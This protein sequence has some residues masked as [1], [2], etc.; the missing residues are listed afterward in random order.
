ME[1]EELYAEDRLAVETRIRNLLWTVSGNYDLSCELDIDSFQKA[2]EISL[3]DAIKQGAFARFFDSEAFG[4][5]LVKKIY[6]G[7]DEGPLMGISQLCLDEASFGKIAA[8]RP[9][10]PDIRKKAFEEILERDFRKLNESFAGRLK[11]AYMRRAL[12]GDCAGEQKIRRELDRVEALRETKETMEIIRCVDEIYNSAVD[13]GFERKHGS[14]KDVLAVSMADLKKYDWKDYLNEEAEEARMEEYLRQMQN[15]LTSLSEEDEKEKEKSKGG[16]VLLDEE[17]VEKMYSYME[18]NYGRS[19]LNELEQQRINYRLCRGAHADC[20]LYFTDGIL[21]ANVKI[22]AQSELARRTAEMNRRFHHQNRRVTRQNIEVLTEI[23]HHA[24]MTRNEEE[25]YAAEYGKIVPNRLWKVG[26]TSGAKLFDLEIKKE[27]SDF[28]VEVL[29]D[30]S[31]SQR[32]RTSRVALQGYIL[33][34]ALSNV[35][36]PHSV[37]GFCSFWDYTVMRRFRD[38]DEGREANSRIF[39]FYASANNRDGLAVRTAGDALLNRPED[40]KI[41]IVLSDGRPNDIIVNRPNSKN[42][43]PY[44]GDYAIKDTASEVRKLRNQGVAVLGVFAGAEKDL[45]AEKK[46]FGKDFAYIK[47]IR[48][49]SRVTGAYLKKQ[50]LN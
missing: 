42:P 11:L 43:A 41:L 27:N 21:F 47:D 46:I 33:S 45:E 34:E 4:L 7:A 17:A 39:E 18:L 26:R 23:L 37:F 8:E 9:G 30:A 10:V 16:V 49:F 13:R 15:Q 22:N 44:F 3:Y 38:F 1:R 28:A 14:L 36:I 31:G 12:T 29:I 2:K 40:Q 5:Y 32:D 35:G 50:V 20:S 25:I 19:Y 24:L 6:L 48:N